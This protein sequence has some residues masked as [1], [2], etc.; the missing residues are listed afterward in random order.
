MMVRLRFDASY[1]FAGFLREKAAKPVEVLL[2][3]ERFL[4][5]K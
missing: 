3:L 4:E 1:G 5:K 2:T